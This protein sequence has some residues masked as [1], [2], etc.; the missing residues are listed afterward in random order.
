MLRLPELTR[1]SSGYDSLQMT[2]LTIRAVLAHGSQVLQYQ[3][4]YLDGLLAAAL[5]QQATGGRGLAD[6]QAA[7]DIP[8]PLQCLWRS[9]EGYPLWAASCFFPAGEWAQSTVYFHKRAPSGRWSSGRNGKKQPLKIVTAMGADME[10]RIPTP[11]LT[12]T[13]IVARAIGNAAAIAELLER[14]NFLG[15]RRNLGMAQVAT[16]H[17]EE[18]DFTVGDVLINEGRLSRAIPEDA[19]EVVGWRPQDAPTLV[20]WTP[21]QW[22][23][24]LFSAGWRVGTSVPVTKGVD[25]FAAAD[26]L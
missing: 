5:V 1:H 11:A 26:H 19:A 12:C 18:A 21:P 6:T 3:P 15:K 13:E 8:L 25:W 22:K 2:G 20:G 24:S 14:V 4:I 10:R 7:Y 9:P 23:P 16:W 17:V